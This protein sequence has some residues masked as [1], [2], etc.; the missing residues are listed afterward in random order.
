VWLSLSANHTVTDPG[1]PAGASAVGLASANARTHITVTA[2]QW[3]WRF[4]YREAPVRVT[5]TCADRAAAPTLVVPA[6][7]PVELSLTSSD[8][9]HALWIPDLAIKKDAMPNH[10]NTLTVT[11]DRPGQWLGR[12]SEYC[13]THHMTMDFYVKAVPADQ[14]QQ[15]LTH[16]GGQA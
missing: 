6:G 12:C 1:R 16:G 13:G 2:F 8:V 11:F 5:G 4:D 15:W 14:Y 7:Q 3:C 9:V 10:V